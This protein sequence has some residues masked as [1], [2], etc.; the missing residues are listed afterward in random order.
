MQGSDYSFTVFYYQN[1]PHRTGF[2]TL[3]VTG[4]VWSPRPGFSSTCP[5][6]VHGR[7][8]PARRTG[9]VS[10]SWGLDC[11]QTSSKKET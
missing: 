10:L 9:L 8:R 2:R 5:A 6:C 7:R 1:E 4:T 3:P 11:W